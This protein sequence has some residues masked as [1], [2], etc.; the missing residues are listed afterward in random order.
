MSTILA[1]LRSVVPMHSLSRGE[2]MRVAELQ[3][4]MLLETVGLTVPPVPETVISAVPRIEIKRLASI[5][6]S[7]SAHWARGHWVVA[8]NKAEPRVRQRFSFAHEFKHVLDS[9]FS[10]F[11]YLDHLGVTSSERGEQ[12]SDYFAGCLLMPRLWVRRAWREGLQSIPAVSGIPVSDA[13]SASTDRIDDRTRSPYG[14]EW[15]E[16]GGAAMTS[17][18][19]GK[20]GWV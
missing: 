10:T 6:V 17:R 13:G 16:E 2:S 15:A 7:G 3:A 20:G 19:R 1:S 12:V 11:L 14:R 9:P 8:V 18:V 4:N 5:P